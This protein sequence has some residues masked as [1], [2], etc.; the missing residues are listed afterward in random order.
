[1]LNSIPCGPCILNQQ[2]KKKSC[3]V[4]HYRLVTLNKARS[5]AVIQTDLRSVQIL[6]DYRITDPKCS[7]LATENPAVATTEALASL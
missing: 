1:M 4:Q 3:S 7:V 6:I 2:Q 5:A